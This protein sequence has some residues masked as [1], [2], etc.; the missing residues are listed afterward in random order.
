[1]MNIWQKSLIALVGASLIGCATVPE[2][3]KQVANWESHQQTIMNIRNWQATGK[4]SVRNSEEASTLSIDWQRQGVR[5]QVVLTGQLGIGRAELEGSGN[6]YVLK[7]N[8]EEYPASSLSEMG[9]MLFTPAL[10]LNEIGFW[11]RGIPAP[12]QPFIAE[13]NELGLLGRLEQAGWEIEY[14]RYQ[15]D[16]PPLPDKLTITQDDAVA[17][18]IVREWQ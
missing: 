11:I 14:E 7:A 2:T 3:Q 16:Q 9:A 13:Y 4:A 18:I 12:N 6:S 10:P 17:K 15:G 5:D 1:M 8:G